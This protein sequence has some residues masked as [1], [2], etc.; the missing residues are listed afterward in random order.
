MPYK[1]KSGTHYHE[2][3]GC[4]GATE[5]CGTEGLAPCQICCGTGARGKSDGSGVS[6]A[7]AGSGSAG[8]SGIFEATEGQAGM[9]GVPSSGEGVATGHDERRTTVA[10]VRHEAA[11]DYVMRLADS[12][13]AIKRSMDA[14]RDGQLAPSPESMDLPGAS[15]LREV[16]DSLP[17][18]SLASRPSPEHD[19][20]PDDLVGNPMTPEE[21]FRQRREEEFMEDFRQR[22]AEAIRQ[23]DRDG[24]DRW[25]AANEELAEYMKG[26]LRR[27]R[28]AS[29]SL[30]IDDE[31]ESILRQ[32]Y[33]KEVPC[34]SWGLAS[35]W[36]RYGRLLTGGEERWPGYEEAK[37]AWDAE[38]DL[39]W[40]ART[41]QARRASTRA[42]ARRDHVGQTSG[43]SV[44]V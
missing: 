13:L 35:Q 32:R 40:R 20:G 7:S 21:A 18:P 28:P 25:R 30:F 3:Y 23:W 1:T 2:T 10:E 43:V 19:I 17:E 4:C 5:A 14:T 44:T 27:E 24:W 11:E 39:M 26:N 38:S 12:L 41:A 22:T 16:I 37:R 31:V 29:L 36:Q 15:R 34:P 9:A 8:G 42:S 33:E 6:P